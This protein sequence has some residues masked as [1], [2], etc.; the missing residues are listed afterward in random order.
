M[1]GLIAVVAAAA[2]WLALGSATPVGA[3]ATSPQDAGPS[4]ATR[5]SMLDSYCVPCH[6]Q[7][8]RTAGLTLDTIGVDDVASSAATWEKVV[9]KLRTGAMPPEGRPRPDVAT[10]DAFVAGLEASLDQAAVLRPNP[11]RP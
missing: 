2:G 7:K 4:A 9:R 10:R 3:R 6:N 1:R 11:G 5:R 8:L